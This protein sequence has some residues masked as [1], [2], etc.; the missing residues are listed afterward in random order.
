MPAR[1]R[2]R[3]QALERDARDHRAERV[4]GEQHAVGKARVAMAEIV[5]KARH[6]RVIG[7]ADQERGQRSEQRHRDQDRL[8]GDAAE[9]RDDIGEAAHRHARSRGDPLRLGA[10]NSHSSIGR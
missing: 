3:L 9:R 1:A 2:I 5:G 10:T 4:G 7:V 6:L 8:L